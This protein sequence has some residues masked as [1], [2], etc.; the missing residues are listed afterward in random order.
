MWP[1]VRVI[2]KDLTVRGGD[3]MGKQ[4]RKLNEF[5]EK[6]S[7]IHNIPKHLFHKDK[8]TNHIRVKIATRITPKK[9]SK[10]GK[11][12]KKE[13]GTRHIST[14]SFKSYYGH[15]G[16]RYFYPAVEMKFKLPKK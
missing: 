5:I 15:E 8:K 7:K 11:L 1:A 14:K 4:D 9:A 12:A 10:I 2:G 3:K 13:M 6:L 16:E